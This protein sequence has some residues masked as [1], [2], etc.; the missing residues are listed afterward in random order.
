MAKKK[1]PAPKRAAKKAPAKSKP[2]PKKAAKRAP[3]VSTGHDVLADIL[4]EP[5]VRKM[6]AALVAALE[7]GP[8][9][10]AR[11]LR[12]V[13]NHVQCMTFDSVPVDR[14]AGFKKDIGASGVAL[15]FDV[16]E[17]RVLDKLGVQRKQRSSNERTQRVARAIAQYGAPHETPDVRRQPAQPRAARAL[18]DDKHLTVPLHSVAVGA[19]VKTPDSVDDGLEGSFA[20]II[21]QG[22]GSVTVRLGTTTRRVVRDRNGDALAEFDA[23]GRA[24]S[25]A[26]STQV[27]VVAEGYD[28][29]C[30]ERSYGDPHVD[31][32]EVRAS[33][34]TQLQF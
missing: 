11:G 32:D 19:T 16:D 15:L 9:G 29:A 3:A 18:V 21:R 8:D 27:V 24:V 12:R 25:W 31:A 33:S 10:R 20:T 30:D 26:P 14:L 7:A 13:W 22:I 1:K 2:T 34:A 5:V 17:Q 28:A 4:P 23:P 6:P